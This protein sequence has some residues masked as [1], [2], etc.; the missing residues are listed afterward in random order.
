MERILDKIVKDVFSK[1][2]IEEENSFKVDFL[3]AVL[4][5][6]KKDGSTNVYLNNEMFSFSE[7]TFLNNYIFIRNFLKLKSGFAILD[8]LN[9]KY[10]FV[11]EMKRLLK[12]GVVLDD[13]Y[14]SCGDFKVASVIQTTWMPQSYNFRC[15]KA[16]CKKDTERYS[17]KKNE[18]LINKEVK[19]IDVNKQIEILFE[20]ME[21]IINYAI[22]EKVYG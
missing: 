15:V 13:G 18:Y 12:M 11:D 9:E 14:I 19:Q 10:K 5:I 1:N 20:I 3:K 21:S 7:K 6:N 17:P 8:N 2:I 16:K 22:E 4:Y